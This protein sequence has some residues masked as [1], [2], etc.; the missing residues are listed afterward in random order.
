MKYTCIGNIDV[1]DFQ[2]ACNVSAKKTVIT[3]ITGSRTYKYWQIPILRI[4]IMRQTR[5]SLRGKYL[6]SIYFREYI[7]AEVQY[8]FENSDPLMDQYRKCKYNYIP[9]T[10]IGDMVDICRYLYR[11]V[12]SISA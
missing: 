4:H 6:L 2:V 5:L 7:L 9:G 3:G 1:L 8:Q 12:T 11:E 10:D